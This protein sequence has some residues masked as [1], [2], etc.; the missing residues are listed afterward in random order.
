MMRFDSFFSKKKDIKQEEE[1]LPKKEVQE[2]DP[3]FDSVIENFEEQSYLSLSYSFP[4]S[5][6]KEL[7]PGHKVLFSIPEEFRNRIVRDVILKHRKAEKYRVDIK[8]DGYDPYG[9]YNRVELHDVKNNE[10]RAWNDPRGL[11]TDKFA[12]MRSSSNPEV[13]ILHDWIAT[14]GEIKTDMA[15]I[16]NVGT[17]KKYSVSNLH[18]F[19]VIFFPENIENAEHE[20]KIYCAGT[21]FIDIKED[22]LLPEYG[23]GSHTNGKYIGAIALNQRSPALYELGNDVGEGVERKEDAIEIKLKSGKTLLQAEVSIGDTEH[24]DHINP[25]TGKNKRLGYAKLWMGIRRAETGRMEW[26]SENI[27]VPPQGV[28][29]GAPK[30]ENLD[31]YEGDTLVIESRDDTS[32]I[33]GWRV[34]YGEK[35]RKEKIEK[36]EKI[37]A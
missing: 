32:Y 18:G 34:T 16:T 29:V 10:W 27:N 20:E 23:G 5:E 33:M 7:K 15:R 2:K 3:S 37:A 4:E 19:E 8:K 14:V 12:E 22:K 36:I 17:N 24:L 11:K 28:L 6:G 1:K 35:E 9:A 21:K 26:F 30:K 25:K 13:E 31:I